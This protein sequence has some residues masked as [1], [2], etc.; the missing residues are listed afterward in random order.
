MIQLGKRYRCSD[1]QYGDP[2]YESRRG[3]GCLL[4]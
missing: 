4:R 2:L 3:N 1:L